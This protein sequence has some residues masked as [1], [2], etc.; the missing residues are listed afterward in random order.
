M[1]P[2]SFAWWLALAFIGLILYASLYP[3][4]GW[5][6]PAE[7]WWG[8]LTAPLSRYWTAFDV[9]SNLLGYVPL[10]FLLMLA[11]LHAARVWVVGLAAWALGVLLSLTVESV[12]VFLPMRVPSNLDLLL[13]SAGTLWGVGLAWWLDRLGWLRRW[14]RLRGRLFTGQASGSLVLLV[15]WPA[16]LLY[17]S[18]V[19]FGLGQVAERLLDAVLMGS[20]AVGMVPANVYAE[21]VPWN[22]CT[23]RVCV[24]LG[25][26]A[27]ALLMYA[28]LR[29][30]GQR[31]LCLLVVMLAGGLAI[32]LSAALTYG[33]VHAGSWISPAVLQGLGWAV[34]GGVACLTL[35][36]RATL[37]ALVIGLLTSLVLLNRSRGLPYLAESVG[38]WEQGRFIRFYG[39][40]QW[41][42]WLWPYGVLGFGLQALLRGGRGHAEGGGD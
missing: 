30:W 31:L 26:L 35:P 7:P 1:R 20:E 29:T 10:G 9:V 13:N 6:L 36:R 37:A 28:E 5:R 16:A 19:P 11:G 18:S 40:S 24:A 15:L 21:W 3:F 33:P 34:L 25:V 39:F 23:Q 38:I 14:T 8:F 2:R 41:L 17:P 4:V 42:G 27:P 32:T 22:E 12:Q